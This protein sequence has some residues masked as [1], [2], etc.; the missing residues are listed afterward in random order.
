MLNDK[1]DLMLAFGYDR[2]TN[3]K[4]ET[5]KDLR[6]YF[7]DK[8]DDFIMIPESATAEDTLVKIIYKIRSCEYQKGYL[9]GLRDKLIINRARA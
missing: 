1:D 8:S 9:D 2:M 3:T 6:V 4:D 5:G 7:G